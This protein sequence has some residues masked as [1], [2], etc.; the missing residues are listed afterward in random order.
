[1]TDHRAGLAALLTR[2]AAEEARWQAALARG[3]RWT[4]DDAAAELSR[5]HARY[6]DLKRSRADFAEH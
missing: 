4:A 3:D 5:L 2:A 1:V 6:E